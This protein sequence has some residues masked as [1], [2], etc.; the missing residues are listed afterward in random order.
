MI[1]NEAMVGTATSAIIKATGGGVST[2]AST[3]NQ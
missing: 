2:V 1:A 3:K